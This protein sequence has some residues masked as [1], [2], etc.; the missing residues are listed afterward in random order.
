MSAPVPSNPEG[1]CIIPNAP[2]VYV[3]CPATSRIRKV[4][5]TVND[6]QRTCRCCE[7]RGKPMADTLNEL[8]R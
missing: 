6:I 1:A 7:Y 8:C 4:G 2:N 5:V 3:T